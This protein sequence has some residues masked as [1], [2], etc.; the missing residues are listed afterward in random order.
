MWIQ[1]LM[2]KRLSVL[3][4][5]TDPANKSLSDFKELGVTQLNLMDEN[6]EI[7]SRLF[8]NLMELILS[9]EPDDHIV[10]DT[11]SACYVPLV[12]YL[13]NNRAFEIIRDHGNEIFI[14]VPITGGPDIVHTTKCLEELTDSFPGIPF[15]IWKNRFHG[16][17]S[18]DGKAF[19][20]FK[21]YGLVSEHISGV[22][23]IP[24]KNPSTFGKDIEHLMT[25]KMTFKTAFNSNLPIMVRQRLRMFW[26]E[27]TVAMDKVLFPAAMEDSGGTELNLVK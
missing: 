10:I 15:I 6:E 17:L 18:M 8:D 2:A 5:D 7:N 20:D 19:E 26:D 13:K 16:D 25:L 23:E 22:V 9:R 1:F 4:I 12:A 11:G 24:H 3:S 21:V 27:I 14:H